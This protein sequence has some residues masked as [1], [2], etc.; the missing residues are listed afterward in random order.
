MSLRGALAGGRSFGGRWPRRSRPRQ[1]QKACHGSKAGYFAAFG[2]FMAAELLDFA[3]LARAAGGYPA[4]V[5][6]VRTGCLL[7]KMEYTNQI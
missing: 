2:R 7:E 4:A 1:E 3:Q 5:E 6:D